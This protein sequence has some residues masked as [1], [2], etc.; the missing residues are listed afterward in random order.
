MNAAQEL[1]RLKA[2][3]LMVLGALSEDPATK[4]LVDAAHAELKSVMEKHGD[5]GLLAL[6]IL[7]LDVGIKQ[8]EES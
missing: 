7:T 8:G 3:R 4:E 6:A 2:E 5:H 1:A